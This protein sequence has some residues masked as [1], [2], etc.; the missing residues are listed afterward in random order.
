ME[1]LG[2]NPLKRHPSFKWKAGNV[3][4]ILKDYEYVGHSLNLVR[5]ENPPILLKNTH[6]AIISEEMFKKANEKIKRKIKNNNYDR[7]TKIL[8]DANSGKTLTYVTS[9]SKENE[10]YYYSRISKYSIKVKKLKMFLYYE[11]IKI[12]KDYIK[13]DQVLTEICRKRILQRD[14][15][16]IDNLKKQLE[17]LKNKFTDLSEQFFNNQINRFKFEEKSKVISNQ[18]NTTENNINNY[19][20]LFTK[21]LEVRSKLKVFLEVF[22]NDTERIELIRKMISTVIINHEKGIIIINYKFGKY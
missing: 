10:D 1:I 2:L 22:D 19:Q 4:E 7:L 21:T 20:T 15:L 17:I 16:D 14:S 12:L 9:K 13:N 3:W 11:C 18:I 8:I 5:K 6:H